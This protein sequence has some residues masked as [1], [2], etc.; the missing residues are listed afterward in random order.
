MIKKQKNTLCCK[1]NKTKKR[2]WGY[3]A[4]LVEAQAGG[5]GR[6]EGPGSEAGAVHITRTLHSKVAGCRGP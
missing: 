6:R 5:K 2:I 4:I 1:K 3:K